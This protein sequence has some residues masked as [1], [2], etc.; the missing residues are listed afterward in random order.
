[1]NNKTTKRKLH[2]VG[3][4]SYSITL[5]AKWVKENNLKD[6]DYVIIEDKGKYLIVRLKK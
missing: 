1:M 3:G 4:Y 2:N 5:P 6:R